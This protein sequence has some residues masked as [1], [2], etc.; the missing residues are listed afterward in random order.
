M[1]AYIQHR[2]SNQRLNINCYLACEGFRQ[3]GFEIVHFKELQEI[4]DL[5]QEAVVVAGIGVIYEGLKT[6]WY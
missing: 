3:M 6:T 1:K 4:D 5:E 2:D